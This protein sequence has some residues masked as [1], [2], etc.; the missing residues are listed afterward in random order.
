M[1]SRLAWFALLAVLAIWPAERV[2]SLDG[3]TVLEGQ[4]RWTPG[5]EAG[6]MKATFEPV[7]ASSW[8]VSFSFN[9]NGPHVYT[10]TAEGSLA[11]GGRLVGRVQSDVGRQQ[12]RFEGTF[13]NGRLDGNHFAK[14][15]REEELS[16]TL[17]LFR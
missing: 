15:G 5:N 1:S 14:R 9:F 12:W 6:D 8:K 2:A 10:G 16:G 11:E 4:W 17:T 13:K 3:L 7:A